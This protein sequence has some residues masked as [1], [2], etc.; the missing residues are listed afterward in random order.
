MG[1]I[2]DFITGDSAGKQADAA[3]AMSRIAGESSAR[4]KEE[5]DLY[6]KNLQPHEL[7][8]INETLGY[9]NAG[10][11]R[12]NDAQ[13]EIAQL[14][15]V[16][17][18]PPARFNNNESVYIPGTDN[19]RDDFMGGVLGST[20]ATN[21]KISAAKAR[22]TELQSIQRPTKN[23]TT[24]PNITSGLN[25]LDQL[26]ADN[27]EEAALLSEMRQPINYDTNDP[28]VAAEAAKAGGGVSLAYQRQMET[29]RRGLRSMGVNPN[30]GMALSAEQDAN[31]DLAAN[32]A[33]ASNEARNTTREG[34]YRRGVDG[35]NRKGQLL[36]EVR[37]GIMNKY[38]MTQGAINT[39]QNQT[40]SK[41]NQKIASLGLAKGIGN[42][43]I[44]HTSLA[45]TGLSNAGNMW[46]NIAD[47]N[48]K[49]VGDAAEA[50]ITGY[51]YSKIK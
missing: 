17:D 31:L 40:T 15:G 20:T 4:G 33:G 44:A 49:M 32:V 46:G 26:S 39:R 3:E 16:I 27:P 43:G 8:F 25:R 28:L 5:W 9:N 2:V 21:E 14:Q 11:K 37:S 35:F 12:Y 30:S 22:I 24:D 18:A 6:K 13:N 50:G 47:R 48:S 19:L 51:G 1:G 36:G 42:T 34:I 29:N 41:F 23:D 38:N 7:E 45:Q 10:M